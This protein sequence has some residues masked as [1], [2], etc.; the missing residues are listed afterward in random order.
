MLASFSSLASRPDVPVL[1]NMRPVCRQFHVW[2]K[3]SESLVGPLSIVYPSSK[4]LIE[5][6]AW[7]EY[8]GSGQVISPRF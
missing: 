5:Q 4:E 2:L 7:T 1:H 8:A 6:Y 3:L